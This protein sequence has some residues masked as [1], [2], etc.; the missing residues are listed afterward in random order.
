MQRRRGRSLGGGARAAGIS[1]SG[2]YEHPIEVEGAVFTPIVLSPYGGWH[3]GCGNEQWTRRTN[4]N[5]L[6]VQL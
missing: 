2:G 4:R 3:G 5:K 6:S 1:Y